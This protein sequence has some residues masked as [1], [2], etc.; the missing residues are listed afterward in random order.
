MLYRSIM[1]NEIWPTAYPWFTPPARI[2]TASGEHEQAS[3]L[4]GV[5]TLRYRH[6]RQG[7]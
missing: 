5:P 1:F 2:L 3:D 4:R 7:D 6:D